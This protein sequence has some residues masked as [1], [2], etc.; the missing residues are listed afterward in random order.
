[1][2]YLRYLRR[3]STMVSNL[4]VQRTT[5]THP[6]EPTQPTL[7]TLPRLQKRLGETTVCLEPTVPKPDNNIILSVALA[8][9]TARRI[10]RIHPHSDVFGCEYC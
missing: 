7:P 8:T 4:Q 10:Y 1:M 5:Y 3:Q 2:H 6:L 9:T